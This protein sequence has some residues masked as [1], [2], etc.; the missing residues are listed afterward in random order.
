L[1]RGKGFEKRDV[2]DMKASYFSRMLQHFAIFRYVFG[3]LRRGSVSL[4]K[5]LVQLRSTKEKKKYFQITLW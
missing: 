2:Y 3:L 1:P 4:G 5:V